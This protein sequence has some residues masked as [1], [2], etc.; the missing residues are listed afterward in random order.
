MWDDIIM[1]RIEAIIDIFGNNVTPFSRIQNWKDESAY[2]TGLMWKGAHIGLD[3]VV[4]HDEYRVLLR[5]R[6]DWEGMKGMVKAALKTVNCAD[7]YPVKDGEFRKSFDFPAQHDEMIKFIERI[8]QE[9]KP[10]QP[11]RA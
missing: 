7:K 6:N 4:A 5:D 8:K 11:T 2:F 10:L 1:Y 3:I 9:L